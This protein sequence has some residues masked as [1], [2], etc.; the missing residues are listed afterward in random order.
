MGFPANIIDTWTGFLP[1][2]TL[3]I[4]YLTQSFAS[5][6][7]ATVC[8]LAIGMSWAFPK[9][10]RLF[11]FVAILASAQRV[12]SLAHWGS[13]VCFGAAIALM[14]AG[15]LTQEWGIGTWLTRLEARLA[16]SDSDSNTQIL[17]DADRK[18]A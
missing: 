5:A 17:E 4:Q 12:V 6:H 10:A 14:M 16:G 8:G 2:G 18:A 3:N 11:F 13:D 7:T 15:L 9:G 1:D